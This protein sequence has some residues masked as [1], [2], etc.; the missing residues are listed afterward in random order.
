MDPL[1]NT[2]GRALSVHCDHLTP[3]QT[4]RELVGL[5]ISPLLQG[6]GKLNKLPKKGI[7][8]ALCE[9]AEAAAPCLRPCGPDARGI[10]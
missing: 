2:S 7:S 1:H 6:F 3:R 5:L 8:M 4:E 10:L 9:R